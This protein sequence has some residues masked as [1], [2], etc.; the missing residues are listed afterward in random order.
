LKKIKK[1]KEYLNKIVA[2]IVEEYSALRSEG[3]SLL[4]K[5][6]ESFQTEKFQKINYRLFKILAATFLGKIC[7]SDHAM[8]ATE[9]MGKLAVDFEGLMKKSGVPYPVWDQLRQD[10]CGYL[11]EWSGR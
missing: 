10:T 3:H 5:S 6:E 9:E 4:P 11:S 7:L 2:A 8:N 1:N